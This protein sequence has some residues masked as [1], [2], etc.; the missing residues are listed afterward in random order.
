MSTNKGGLAEAGEASTR[1]SE[2]G[3]HHVRDIS[4]AGRAHPPARLYALLSIVA[5]LAT[6]G[7]KLA[8]YFLTG[9]VG[10]LSDAAESLANLLAALVAF[11]ML[12]VAERPPDEEHAYGHSKAEYFSS[13]VESVLILLAAAG[14]GWA[15]INRLMHPQPLENVG[16]GLA[17]TLAAT[18]INGGVALVLMRA[19]RRLRSITLTADA[20]HLLVQLTGWLV[21]DPLIGLAVA[22]NIVWI[23]IRLFNATAHGLLDTALPE[24]DR[25]V[26]ARVLDG[27]RS[28]GIRFH[29]V[30]TRMAG[31]RRFISMHVLVPGDWSVQRGH[32]LCEQ[33][34]RELITALP[35]STVFTHL[36][37]IEDPM[38]WAD[39]ELDRREGG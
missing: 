25:Q 39:Q 1:V 21:L 8:A 16:T 36:E 18:A 6:I 3:H 17:A 34:E 2:Q 30:R 23:G 37:P 33:I 24:A 20:H 31:Q 26:I 15:A 4:A 32:A 11:W 12:A 5:A 13:G 7:L 27:Y 28:R 29:A 19:G 10:L 14:I 22:A 9:S 35:G 38:S